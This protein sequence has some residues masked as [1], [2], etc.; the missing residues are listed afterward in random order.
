M[1]L[2][3]RA[4]ISIERSAMISILRSW[5]DLHRATGMISIGPPVWRQV[6][7]PSVGCSIMTTITTT[8]KSTTT[9]HHDFDT[10]AVRIK[11]QPMA[12]AGCFT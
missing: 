4:L 10:Q 7:T 8:S 6:Q 2:L 3:Q 11:E 9:L 1:V 5:H 12:P